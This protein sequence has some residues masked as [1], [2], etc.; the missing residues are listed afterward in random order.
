MTPELLERLR[1]YEKGHRPTRIQHGEPTFF[2]LR[3]G[4][5][6]VWYY[7]NQ[8]GEIEIFDLMGFHPE[9]GEELVPIT[10][11]VVS[12]WQEQSKRR[13][14]RQVDLKSH[15]LF[16]PLS[17][18]S[19]VWFWRSD[20]GKYEFYD[21]DGYHPRTGE[22]LISLT[23]DDGPIASFC[24][25]GRQRAFSRGPMRDVTDLPIEA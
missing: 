21:N 14:P 20:E 10:K 25:A 22:R 17:G 7:K 8:K 16:D 2:D 11:E 6:V 12:L 24:S 23:K 5:A 15:E 19:R 18:E 9:T 4:E 1:E 13:P 3:T